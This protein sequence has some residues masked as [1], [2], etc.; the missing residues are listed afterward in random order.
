MEMK[1]N[2]AH[3]CEECKF[4]KKFIET[5]RQIDD[6][7]ARVYLRIM[8]MINNTDQALGIPAP[9]TADSMD[10]V[11]YFK[12]VIESSNNTRALFSEWYTEAR[13]KYHVP[14]YALFDYNNKLFFI[15]VDDHGVINIEH[16]FVKK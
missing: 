15:C 12:T 2:Q 3:I 4:K 9:N 16:D 14:D 1:P 8:T 7:D 6:N 5:E 11:K 13:R 10:R